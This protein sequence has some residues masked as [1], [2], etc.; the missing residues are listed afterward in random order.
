MTTEAA[1]ICREAAAVIE[2][3]GHAK[4]RFEIED[5]RVC[6]WGA[7]QAAQFGDARQWNNDDPTYT[8]LQRFFASKFRIPFSKTHGLPGTQFNDLPATTGKDVQKFLLAA[9]DEL[10]FYTPDSAA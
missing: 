3:R 10:E 6:M 5:G 4:G 8:E 7:L 2:Q 9:A 1:N